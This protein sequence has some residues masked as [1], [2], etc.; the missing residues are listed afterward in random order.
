MSKRTKSDRKP[1]EAAG[2]S[3]STWYRQ[4]GTSRTP[5][6]ERRAVASPGDKK[7]RRIAKGT[8]PANPRVPDADVQRRLNDAVGEALGKERIA[9]FL[10]WLDTL[11]TDHASES[12]LSV[13]ALPSTWRAVASVLERRGA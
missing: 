9:I 11:L 2:M 6:R 13:D 12:M 3:R 5:V 8:A 1:W 7:R 10:A 4:G